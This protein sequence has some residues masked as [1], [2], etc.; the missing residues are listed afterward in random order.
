LEIVLLK[1]FQG[2]LCL[3]DKDHELVTGA[4]GK[5]L[6]GKSEETVVLGILDSAV[7]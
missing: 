3:F 7:T 4:L 6:L 1:F 5:D 2:S